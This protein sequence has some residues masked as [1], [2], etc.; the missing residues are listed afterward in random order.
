MIVR[1]LDS[2]FDWTYGR[3]KNNYLSG[4]SAVAQNISTRLKSF[5]GDCFYDTAA[6]I[7]WFNR[8]GSKDIIAL[9]LDVSAVILNTRDVTGIVQLSINLNSARKLTIQYAVT[10]AYVTID[11]STG[12]ISSVADFLT[13]EDGSIITTEDGD[14]ITI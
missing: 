10:T 14:G 4:R 1:A 12:V 9:N 8:I 13:A 7:D 5:L 2:N 11:N 6:G 3:G